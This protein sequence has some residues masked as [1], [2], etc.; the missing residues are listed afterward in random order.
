MADSRAFAFACE[1]LE[2]HSSLDRLAARGTVRLA[3]REAGLEAASV[4]PCQ[5]RVVA[6]RVLP[7]ELAARGVE[8]AEA[9]CGRLVEGLAGLAPEADVESPEAVFARLGGAA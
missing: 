1:A 3:L 5:L 8:D 7:R 2:A 6:E 4:T 9:V